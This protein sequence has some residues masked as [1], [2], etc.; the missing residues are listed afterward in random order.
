MVPAGIRMVALVGSMCLVAFAAIALVVFNVL[1]LKTYMAVVAEGHSSAPL[2]K[3]AWIIS[4][5]S[6]WTGPLILLLA[7]LSIIFALVHVR[8]VSL[9]TRIACKIAIMN[10]AFILVAGAIAV[11]LTLWA[12][13]R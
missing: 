9:P 7:P 2:S 8:S 5:V 10:A 13:R 6:W 3:A 4:L 12:V 11:V 1:Q